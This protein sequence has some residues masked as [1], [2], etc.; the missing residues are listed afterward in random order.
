MN[1]FTIINHIYTDEHSDWIHEV[2]DNEI[3]PF[4]INNFLMRNDDNILYCAEL[5]KFT[6]ILT[7][8]RWLHL[9][10]SLIPKLDRVPYIT[11]IK[12]SES[13]FLYPELIS[14]IKHY[15]D[16]EQKNDTEFDKYILPVVCKD[17]VKYMHQFGMEKKYWKKYGLK[18]GN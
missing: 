17:M 6:F 5:N 11:Y 10:W 14:R 7:P 2:E 3:Q 8:K 4:N 9:C 1:I 18:R 15:L 16:I 12:K 13:E